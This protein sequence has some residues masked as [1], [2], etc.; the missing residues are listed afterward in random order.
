MSTELFTDYDTFAVSIGEATLSMRL[1]A[2]EEKHWALSSTVAGDIRLQ[3]GFEG[4]GTIAEGETI[5][6]GWVFY[7]QFPSGQA[8]GETTSPN[9]VFVA[10]PNS[11]FC[12]TCHPLHHWLTICI[13]SQLLFSSEHELEFA[14]SARPQLLKPPPD[15]TNKFT[16]LAHRFISIADSRPQLLSSDLAVQSFQA[17]FLVAAN[18]LFIKNQ[19]PTN[20]HFA[21]WRYQ[22]KLAEEIALRDFD[23]SLS[24]VELSEKTEVPE[25][26]LRT[27]FQRCFGLSPAQYLRVLRLH[28]AR[29]QLLAGRLYNTTVTQVAFGLGFWDLGR[30]AGSYRLLFGELP[31]AT[32]KKPVKS[33]SQQPF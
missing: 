5:S 15:F 9:D 8:N 2:L 19:N 29:Q 17:E 18:E 20:R 32:L 28:Q 23:L 12:L 13:P 25:R 10:P 31:S 4:G 7:S 22:A 6:D 33:G 30:F 26:T 24:I 11:E 21:R 16:T 14:S 27:L 3:K 1:T